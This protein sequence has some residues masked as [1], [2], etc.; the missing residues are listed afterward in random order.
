M[1]F[2]SLQPIL[3]SRFMLNL[4][5]AAENPGPESTTHRSTIRFNMSIPIGNIGES[6]EFATQP[7]SDDDN[8][9]NE[10]NEDDIAHLTESSTSSDIRSL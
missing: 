8:L 9:E 3:I 1:T 5:Q 4:R 7:E 2:L 6:L 10:S